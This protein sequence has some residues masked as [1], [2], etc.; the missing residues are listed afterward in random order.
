M[1]SCETDT[2]LVPAPEGYDVDFCNPQRRADIA[3]YWC[4][5][6]GMVLSLLFTAQ[7]LYVKLGIGT[8]WQVDDSKL[9]LDLRLHTARRIPLR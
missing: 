4:F 9:F 1:S 6:V 5:G 7:R 3:T 8:G 2:A